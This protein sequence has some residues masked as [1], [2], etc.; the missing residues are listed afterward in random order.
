MKQKQ[1]LIIV[2]VAVIV[3][4][5]LFSSRMFFV[6]DPGERAV[7]FN[8]ISG[9]L[10]KDDIE[11]TGLKMIA[12]WNNLFKYEVKEQSREEPLDILDKNGLSLSMDITI[13]FNPIYDR[14]G[15]LHET[16]GQNYINR[17]IIPEMRS[18]VRNVAG[19]YSAEEIYSTKR[20]EVELTMV[21]ETMEVLKENNIDMRALL[22]RSIILPEGIKKAIELKLTREQ[23]SL[24]MVYVKEKEEQEAD[25]K[26][27]E[28]KGISDYNRI[29]N[30]S[31]TA[32]I[33]KQKGIDATLKLA[34]SANA[35]VVTLKLAESANAKV[36]VIGSGKDGMPLILG[37]N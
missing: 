11:G 9:K 18:T 20:N 2:V 34:E 4:L 21:N 6:I 8:T 16:F 25:R 22:I 24:A 14:I 3:A 33:L 23:E 1:T 12:P 35:K 36:V 15:Y 10:S 19:R 29:L 7:V 31:L 30:A 28:A 26:R 5:L 13:R 37:G 17:L 32:N 27:I